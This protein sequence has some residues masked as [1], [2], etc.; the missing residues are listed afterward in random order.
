MP[1]VQ[2]R[3]V[4][5]RKVYYCCILDLHG[6]WEAYP[7]NCFVYSIRSRPRNS[8]RVW[9]QERNLDSLVHESGETLADTC[10]APKIQLVPR[11]CHVDRWRFERKTWIASC[12][13]RESEFERNDWRGFCWK[14]KKERNQKVSKFLLSIVAMWW[15][16]LL[17]RPGCV[18]E[19]LFEIYNAD[20]LCWYI[21][22][23]AKVSGSLLHFSSLGIF[24]PIFLPAIPTLV[25]ISSMRQN[26]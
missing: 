5:V 21:F 15:P 24:F 25:T 20:Y 2:R 9:Q 8:H 13:W 3:H 1:C 6:R 22:W 7:I 11:D 14:S 23:R 16:T 18:I 26:N 4:W 19:P 10:G 12:C 17:T